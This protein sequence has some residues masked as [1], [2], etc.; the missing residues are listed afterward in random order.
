[1][2]HLRRVQFVESCTVK[3][4]VYKIIDLNAILLGV[5]FSVVSIALAQANDLGV[6][7]VTSLKITPLELS[8]PHDDHAATTYDPGLIPLLGH[9][10][11][12]S[13]LNGQ[14][15][16][17]GIPNAPINRVL[18]SSFGLSY[19][20]AESYVGFDLSQ[21][22]VKGALFGQDMDPSLGVVGGLS[23]NSGRY[24]GTLE[25]TRRASQIDDEVYSFIG[26]IN[27]HF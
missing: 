7:D 27:I 11:I 18:R 14:V 20:S 25:G 16:L 19:G 4:W 5:C 1:M 26:K 15:Y 6:S 12:V 23:L 24:S 3:F 22:E 21:S 9:S 10:R 13:G 17:P 8:I 2:L